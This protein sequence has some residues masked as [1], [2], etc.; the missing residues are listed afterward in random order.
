MH[1][2]HLALLI[3]SF[4]TADML[5]PD[6]SVV[7]NKTS[8]ESFDEFVTRHTSSKPLTYNYCVADLPEPALE[9]IGVLQS[10]HVVF[11]H[12]DRSPIASL[13]Q[14]N[15]DWYDCGAPAQELVF[16]GLGHIPV[17]TS[18][19]LPLRDDMWKGDC[20]FGQLTTRGYTQLQE[21]GTAL[22]NRY[23]SAFPNKIEL[24]DI[25]VRST[26]VPRT[27]QSLQALL[28]KFVEVPPGTFFNLS[29]I[30]KTLDHFAPPGFTCPK[31]TA[32]VKSSPDAFKDF[33]SVT[34]DLQK[35][36]S[37]SLH[38]SVSLK[39]EELYDIFQ[40]SKCHDK[41]LPINEQTFK[42]ITNLGEWWSFLL[43]D[44]SRVEEY[45]L[46]VGGIWNEIIANMNNGGKVHLYSSH[47]TTIMAL[48]AGLQSVPKV[49]WP[50]FRSQLIFEHWIQNS[51]ST[52]RIVYN[53]QV[54]STVPKSEFE[55]KFH[56]GNTC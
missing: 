28:S 53:N 43:F 48:L 25:R 34:G 32:L 6:M 15:V 18:V 38:L 16:T 26:D 1:V 47:D 2:A 33:K 9:P 41:P 7:P 23:N 8:E 22:K 42:T 49:P 24:G 54:V 5:G 52:I 12:G 19:R 27:L 51:V 39:G 31:L 55:S 17:S 4:A 30:P 11:R 44:P 3:T 50:P 10:V 46:R 36:V 29:M 40:C 13:P 37:S 45:S 35:T 21:L 20:G 56:F 14:N